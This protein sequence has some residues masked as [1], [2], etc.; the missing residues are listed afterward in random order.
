ML[1]PDRAREIGWVRLN[2]ELYEAA[3]GVARC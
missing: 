1:P 2:I 3:L